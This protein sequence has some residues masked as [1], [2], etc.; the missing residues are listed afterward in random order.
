MSYTQLVIRDCFIK[1][2]RCLETPT[3]G[4]KCLGPIKL[5]CRFCPLDASITPVVPQS[6]ESFFFSFLFFF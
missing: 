4:G 3:D 1:C 5:Q 2:F 6:V